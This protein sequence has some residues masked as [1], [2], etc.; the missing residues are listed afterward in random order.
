MTFKTDDGMEVRRVSR[1]LPVKEKKVTKKHSL[2]DYA[3]EQKYVLYFRFKKKDYALGQF[4]RFDYGP[5]G[6][7]P[8]IQQKGGEQILLAGYDATEYYKPYML[9]W[10]ETC[11]CVRLYEEV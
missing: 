3:D 1:W 11:E 4:M 7:C 9:E 6:K 2:Y 5:G 10:N 8:V